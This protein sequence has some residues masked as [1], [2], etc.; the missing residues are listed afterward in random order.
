MKKNLVVIVK[1][2]EGCG[3]QKEQYIEGP[4]VDNGHF[5]SPAAIFHLRVTAARFPLGEFPDGRWGRAFLRCQW[6]GGRLETQDCLIRG[7]HPT[8]HGDGF[9]DGHLS[10]ADSMSVIHRPLSRTIGRK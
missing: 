3:E 2:G 8:A 5:C 4:T 6:K 9:R 10:P 1:C 7:P